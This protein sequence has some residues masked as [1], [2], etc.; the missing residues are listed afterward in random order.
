MLTG[1]D[2]FVNCMP[3]V[4][5]DPV[6]GSFTASYD[7]SA[8]SAPAIAF[9]TSARLLVGNTSDW[10]FTVTPNSSGMVAAGATV[11]GTHMKQNGSGSGSLIPCN[12]CNQTWR[13]EV[14]WDAGGTLVT[15]TLGPSPVQCVF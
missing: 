9:I 11:N 3:I 15:D 1:M 13:L 8:G 5:P 2:M 7:N 12:A 6:N 14:T 4:P 10:N